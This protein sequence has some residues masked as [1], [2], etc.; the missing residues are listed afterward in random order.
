M[1]EINVVNN[2]FIVAHFIEFLQ[3]SPTLS[4]FIWPLEKRCIWASTVLHVIGMK[5][6]LSNIRLLNC[7]LPIISCSHQK[8]ETTNWWFWGIKVWEISNTWTCRC[9]FGPYV[10]RVYSM[11]VAGKGEFVFKK[12]QF[13][14]KFLTWD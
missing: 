13:K 4:L 5:Q 10:L 1:R 11:C 12:V 9:Q 8:E 2:L 7:C 14:N 6:T 3:P